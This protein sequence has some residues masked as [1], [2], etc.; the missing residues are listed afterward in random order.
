MRRT[1]ITLLGAAVLLAGCGS[2]HP[3]AAASPVA[4]AL[5]YFPSQSPF[6]ALVA[7]K[8]SA[9]A[10]QA[11]QQIESR[12]PLI[13]IARAAAIAK[14][15]QYG[16]NYQ[17]DLQPLFGNPVAF[18]DASASL[19]AFGRQFL[20]VWVTRDASKLHTLVGELG[21]LRKLGSHDGAQLYGGSSSGG[22]AIE[23]GTIVFAATQAGVTSALDRHA[24]SQGISYSG[25]SAAL[26]GLDPSASV[27]LYGSLTSALSTPQAAAARRVP[28]V[29]ALRSYGASVGAAATGL[30]IRFRLNTTGGALAPS[31]LPIAGG[32]T[33][34]GLVSGLPIQ[35]GVRDPAQIGVFAEAAE[36]VA[37]PSAYAKFLR[38]EATI[39]RKAGVDINNLLS[40]LS[41][42]LVVDSDTHST[43]VRA[44]LT[45]PA[46]FSAAISKLAAASAG[47]G[48]HSGVRR[49]GGGF[50]S[51]AQSGRTG[52]FGVI[53]D[54]V[55]LG[56]PPAGGSLKPSNLRSFAAAPSAPAAAADGAVSF[57]VAL[58]ELLALA[59]KGPVPATEQQLFGLLGDVT[60]SLAATPA[61]VTGSATLA[62]K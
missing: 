48:S 3:G 24:R 43:F 30:T 5:S 40:Q 50:Y 51:Y 26:S 12:F 31:Q 62:L 22:L 1:L 58:P 23:G 32:A 28:W 34:P 11:D 20:I 15:Q 21:G 35:A 49:L 2:S 27:Q 37:S 55:V 47:F 54:Q 38:S 45:D 19:T 18:G 42:D 4:S 7:T 14:L 17:K 6:V 57:R 25:Y 13:S 33:S 53:G 56:I 29:A 8:P 46:T 10:Q 60:G 59:I 36:Q 61:A 41:G 52:L 16:L 44:G 9:Q 39:R